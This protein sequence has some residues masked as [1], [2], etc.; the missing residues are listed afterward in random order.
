VDNQ[1]KAHAS[2][3]VVACAFSFESGAYGSGTWCYSAD[4]D[5]EYNE[6]I[7]SKGSVRF[8]SFSPEPIRLTRAGSTEEIAIGDPPHVHQPLIQSIV[9][10]LNGQGRCPSTGETALRTAVAMDSILRELR[11]RSD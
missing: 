4:R 6:I 5:E 10:E 9:D 3:D 8:S 2:E 1:A 7:G 11:Q